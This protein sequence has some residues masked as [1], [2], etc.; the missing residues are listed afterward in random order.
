M[1]VWDTQFFHG[2]S[3]TVIGHLRE[4]IGDSLAAELEPA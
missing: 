2:S 3:D 1:S 4:M